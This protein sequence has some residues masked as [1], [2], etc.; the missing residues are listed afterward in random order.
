MNVGLDHLI[1]PELMA[2]VEES[3]AFFAAAEAN[4]GSPPQPDLFTAEGLRQARSVLAARPA[5]AGRLVT[6]RVAESEGRQVPVR[7]IAPER[8]RP[9]GCRPRDSWRRVLPQLGGPK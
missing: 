8:G 6:E 3:R 1:D 5:P 9:G 2:Y 4:A 7:I